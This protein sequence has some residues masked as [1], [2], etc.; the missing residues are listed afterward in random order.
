MSLPQIQA[1][2]R[3]LRGAELLVETPHITRELLK[4]LIEL[5]DSPR[6][7]KILDGNGAPVGIFI[8]T[9]SLSKGETLQ[10]A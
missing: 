7:V 9:H 5:R 8:P 2:V 10:T 1:R 4:L 3:E 6:A